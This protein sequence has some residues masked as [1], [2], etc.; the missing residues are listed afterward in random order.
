MGMVKIPE[1]TS[2]GKITWQRKK[3][4]RNEITISKDNKK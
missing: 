2:L 1:R 3:K 4:Q